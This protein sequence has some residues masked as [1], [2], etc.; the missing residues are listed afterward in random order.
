MRM[1]KIHNMTKAN[2]NKDAEPQEISFNANHVDNGVAVSYR[3]YSYH[4][5]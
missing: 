1:A 5:M 4:M 3:E 2:A